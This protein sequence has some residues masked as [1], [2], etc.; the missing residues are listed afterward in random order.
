MSLMAG[1]GGAMFQGSCHCGTVQFE[2]SEP[3]GKLVDCNCSACRRFGALW[4]HVPVGSVEI[5]AAPDSTISYRHGDRTLAF[6]TCRTCGCTTHWEN[7]HQGGETMA[8]NFRMCDP[9]VVDQ[10]QI[11]RFDGADTWQFID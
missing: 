10:F 6:H 11:K 1:Q 4:G 8:V 5:I 9:K 7:L 3:P 2:L